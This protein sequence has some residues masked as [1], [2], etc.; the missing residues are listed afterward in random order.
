MIVGY[1]KWLQRY[2]PTKIESSHA[3]LKLLG[4]TVP[5]EIPEEHAVKLLRKTMHR[6]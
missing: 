3:L 5:P 2:D 1:E 6:M 4:V